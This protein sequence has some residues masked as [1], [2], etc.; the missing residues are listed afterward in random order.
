MN[1]CHDHQQITR[2]NILQIDF[3]PRP[4]KLHSLMNKRMLKVDG[5]HMQ[6]TSLEHNFY[7]KKHHNNIRQLRK[8]LK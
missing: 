6:C 7:I 1:I 5:L 2:T 8:F 4:I 3:Q